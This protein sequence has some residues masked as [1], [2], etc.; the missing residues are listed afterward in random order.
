[1]KKIWLIVAIIVVIIIIGVII[2]FY[3]HNKPTVSQ[4]DREKENLT[5]LLEQPD[6]DTGFGLRAINEQGQPV[7]NLVLH[8]SVYNGDYNNYYSDY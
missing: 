6:S 1:M 4:F 8:I 3:I 7:P 2:F 5:S